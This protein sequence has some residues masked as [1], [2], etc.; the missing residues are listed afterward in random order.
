MKFERDDAKIG[1]LVLAALTLFASLAFH[2]TLRLLL[3]RELLHVVVLKNVS[4]LSVGTEVQLQGL[5]VGQ[6]N[7]VEMRREGTAYHFVATI[8][9]QPDVVLWKGT[10]AVVNTRLVGGSYLDLRLPPVEERRVEL[11]PGEPM[12]GE[13]ASSVNSLVTSLDELTRNLNLSVSELRA[14]LKGR[15]LESVLGHPEVKGALRESVAAFSAFRTAAKVTEQTL[16]H[17][18]GTLV[19]LERNMTS[20]EKSL[21]IVQG[22]LERRGTDID[23]L[24]V[25]LGTTLVQLRQLG[26]DLDALLKNAGPDAVQGLRALSRTLSSMEELIE[27]LKAKPNRVVFGTPSDKERGDARKRVEDARRATGAEPSP[28]PGPSPAPVPK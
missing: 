5:R 25:Q 2:R 11:R 23:E 17:G 21:G 4:D 10:K 15:G 26:V 22:L 16:T 13:T 18:D 12:D 8:G 20:L 9:I 1:L 28:A 3:N 19:I 6:T 7:A 24:I 14:E 27:L